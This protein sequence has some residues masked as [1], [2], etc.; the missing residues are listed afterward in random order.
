MFTRPSLAR[1]A[2]L[3]ALACA[4]AV[5][6][7]GAAV[8]DANPAVGTYSVADRGAGGAWQGGPL[9]A[10]GTLG[11]GGMVEFPPGDG[12]QLVL[13]V[14]P[15]NWQYTDATDSAIVLCFNL[16]EL[17]PQREPAF[18]VCAPPL[19]VT[20]GTA[21]LIDPGTGAL[22]QIHVSFHR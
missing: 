4:A 5:P 16:T 9:F 2:T 7:A 12:G 8:A 14:T 17:Q 19:P 15:L 6:L 20:G 18:E 13:K 1:L 21:S 3:S 10:D 22:A 11:G